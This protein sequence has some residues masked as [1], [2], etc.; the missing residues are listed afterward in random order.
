MAL[1][2]KPFYGP[3]APF[4][5]PEVTFPDE[6]IPINSQTPNDECFEK[7]DLLKKEKI[8]RQV[9]KRFRDARELIKKLINII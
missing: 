9:E 8:N 4:L 3:N 2:I 7:E 1:N 6:G 5:H